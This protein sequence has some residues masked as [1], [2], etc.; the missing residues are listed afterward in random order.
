MEEL[1]VVLTALSGEQG[2]LGH[3][4]VVLQSGIMQSSWSD[5]VKL[6][7]RA[8]SKMTLSF[9]ILNNGSS[10]SPLCVQYNL[11]EGSFKSYRA[12]TL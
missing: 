8:S 6:M 2:M 9:L 10:V 4:V 3:A 11:Y 1:I 12:C 7:W 5:V